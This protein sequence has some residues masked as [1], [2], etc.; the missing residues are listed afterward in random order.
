MDDL[1][2][3]GDQIWQELDSLCTTNTEIL[4]LQERMRK[5]LTEDDAQFSLTL[6]MKEIEKDK[7]E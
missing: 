4:N 2:N 3:P 5:D 6:K 1:N 7:F